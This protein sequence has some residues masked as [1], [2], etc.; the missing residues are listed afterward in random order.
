MCIL[1]S[2]HSIRE[3][4]SAVNVEIGSDSCEV[5]LLLCT[6][7]CSSSNG[8]GLALSIWRA[9][10]KSIFVFVQYSAV[11]S[12]MM[13]LL[14]A[15]LQYKLADTRNSKICIKSKISMWIFIFGL[16]QKV[17]M[18]MVVRGCSVLVYWIYK[19]SVREMVS[20]SLSAF[21]YKGAWYCSPSQKPSWNVVGW[22]IAS[23][24]FCLLKEKQPWK[25]EITVS[26]PFPAAKTS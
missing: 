9:P 5:C 7:M 4:A 12:K 11:I 2:S 14:V 16:F 1:G 20:E 17:I 3:T 24:S 13:S 26:Y 21:H 6:D 8:Q 19:V 25:L 15:L 22:A 18:V 23:G 10:T